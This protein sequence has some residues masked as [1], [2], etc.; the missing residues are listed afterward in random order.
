MEGWLMNAGEGR[1]GAVAVLLFGGVALAALILLAVPRRF[2]SSP[3]E[4]GRDPN[5]AVKG[6]WVES[7]PSGIVYYH[8]R[9][10]DFAKW[11]AGSEPTK[12]RCEYHRTSL[13]SAIVWSGDILV[14]LTEETEPHAIWRATV[15]GGTM[16][17]TT[18]SGTV[19]L[20]RQ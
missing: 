13:P 10:S 3:V 1:W 14:F 5:H 11:L 9:D 7:S 15:S 8:F 12:Q 18:D 16:T 19:D 17:I 20:G 2:L 6:I 4:I